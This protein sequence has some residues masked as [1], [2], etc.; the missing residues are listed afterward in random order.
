MQVLRIKAWPQDGGSA[1]D[2]RGRTMLLVRMRPIRIGRKSVRRCHAI[3]HIG[4]RR[5]PRN[6]ELK[7]LTLYPR[8]SPVDPCVIRS[9]PDTFIVQCIVR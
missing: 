1:D 4:T 9:P 2:R 7:Y 3:P 5:M 8:Q 6:H